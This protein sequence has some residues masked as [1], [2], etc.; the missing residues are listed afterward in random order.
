MKRKLNLSVD[1]IIIGNL[2]M[3]TNQ[4]ILSKDFKIFNFNYRAIT[5]RQFI[6]VYKVWP[7]EKKEKFYKIIGGKVFSKKVKDLYSNILI[8][9]NQI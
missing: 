9:D 8:K 7:E 6:N 1:Q 5:S 3:P 4:R 2:T